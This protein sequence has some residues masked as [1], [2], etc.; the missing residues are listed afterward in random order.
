MN[1][2][3]AC[4]LQKAWLEENSHKRNFRKVLLEQLD[5]NLNAIDKSSKTR[6]F[7]K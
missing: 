6:W 1:W 4:K 2:N 3:N 7:K 5:E